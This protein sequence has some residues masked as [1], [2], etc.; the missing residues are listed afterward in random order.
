MMHALSGEL[1]FQ[2]YG[3]EDSDCIYS[4]SRGGLNKMLMSFAEATGKV[5]IRFNERVTRYDSTQCE[6]HLTHE[7]SGSGAGR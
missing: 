7:K 1:T 3:K 5:K 4:I 6:L 2:P